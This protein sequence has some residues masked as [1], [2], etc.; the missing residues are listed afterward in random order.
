MLKCIDLS[1]SYGPVPAL[2]RLNLSVAAGEVVALVGANGAGKSSCLKAMMGL[3][4]GKGGLELDGKDISA[5]TTRSRVEAGLAL[6]P[7][8]RH[9][10][11][12]MSVMEN[13]ELGCIPRARARYHDLVEEMLTL[14]PR[15]RERQKQ[16]AGSLSGGEQQMLAI[17]R[18]LMSEPK[19]ILLDEPTLG[20]APIIVDQIADLINDLRE[21][22]IAVLLAEQNAEMA[23]GVADT[24]CVLETGML[25]KTGAAREIAQD[26]SVR[27]A[28]LGAPSEEESA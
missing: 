5:A 22:G 28:Y 19:V 9:V 21:R 8:G 23:L 20:L 12:E 7:E 16:A 2:A 1:V 26:S 27:S 6:S 25:V 11:P 15:L 14:F 24:A 13:L 3:V 4:P 17:G 10:F 18:A